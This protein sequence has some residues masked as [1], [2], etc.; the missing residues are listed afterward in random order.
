MFFSSIFGLSQ[1]PQKSHWF[2]LAWVNRGEL[3]DRTPIVDNLALSILGFG[4]PS[5]L[6]GDFRGLTVLLS[7]AATTEHSQL[8]MAFLYLTV[9]YKNGS[10]C[11]SFPVGPEVAIRVFNGFQWLGKGGGRIGSSTNARDPRL[12]I[13]SKSNLES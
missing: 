11:D 2:L 6:L 13:K 12:E 3:E 8:E 7:L 10:V 5:Q 4:L 9:D 1:N